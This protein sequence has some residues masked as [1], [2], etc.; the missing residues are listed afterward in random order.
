M[1]CSKCHQNAVMTVNETCIDCENEEMYLDLDDMLN[2]PAMEEYNVYNIVGQNNNE[3]LISEFVN[4]KCVG[5]KTI[6]AEYGCEQIVIRK[7]DIKQ[8]IEYLKEYAV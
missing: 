2:K 4:D 6:D 1:K 8:L 5:I 7:T 3:I